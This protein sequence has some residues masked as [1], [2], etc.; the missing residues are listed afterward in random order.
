MDIKFQLI[1]NEHCGDCYPPDDCQTHRLQ[2]MTVKPNYKS[3]KW[4]GEK[5]EKK[6]VDKQ[7]N[8]QKNT[9]SFGDNNEPKHVLH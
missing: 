8:K 6:T 5:K 3:W 9:I 1:N 7:T 2:D 4:T